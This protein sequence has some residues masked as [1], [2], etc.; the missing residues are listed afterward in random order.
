MTSSLEQ[1]E[2]VLEPFLEEFTR[3]TGIEVD[4]EVVPWSSLWDRIMTAVSS[5]RG[6]DVV[7]IGKAWTASLQAT[8]ALLPFTDEVMDEIGGADKFV[9]ATLESVGVPGEP[10]AAV[11]LYTTAYALFYNTTLFEAA[12][13]ATAPDT[14]QEFVDDAKR[15]TV[16]TDGDG[17]PDQWGV[18]IVGGSGIT[19]AHQAFILGR[20]QGGSLFDD[21]GDPQFDSDAQVAAVQRYVDLMATE[22]VVAPGNAEYTSAVEAIDQLVSGGAAMFFGQSVHESVLADIGFEDY[23]VAPLPVLD[24]LPAGGRDVRSFVGGSNIAVFADTGHRDAALSLVEFL[25][26]PGVQADW[27]AQI[28]TLPVVTAAYD[29]GDDLAEATRVFASVLRDHAEAMPQVPDHAQMETLV[30]GAITDLIAQAATGPVTEDDVRAALAEA[31]AQ[32]TASR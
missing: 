14:W 8:G 5:G 30:G 20:Q 29:E 16:D 24:P 21:D 10:P 17:E 15:L 26:R 25:T 2:A 7:T 23:A 9:P 11:P 32:L 22:H 18:T 3:S 31:D 13:I 28:D 19:A 4:V 12:G 6:P 1:D 27:T